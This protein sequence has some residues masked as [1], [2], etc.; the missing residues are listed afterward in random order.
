MYFH[1]FNE[2]NVWFKLWNKKNL[3]NVK[4]ETI[5]FN[6]SVCIKMVWLKLMCL[7]C[8]NFLFLLNYILTAASIG[9]KLI[10]WY[11]NKS[12]LTWVTRA[13]F[14]LYSSHK[15]YITLQK[16]FIKWISFWSRHYTIYKHLIYC[17]KICN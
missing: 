8:T 11:E 6:K 10:G 15:F 3:I 12:K 1:Y 4:G 17:K 9:L 2:I 14:V 16:W 5:R 7:H 13:A